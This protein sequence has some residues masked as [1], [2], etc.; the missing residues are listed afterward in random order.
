MAEDLY[1]L[2]SVHHLFYKALGLAERD[3]LLQEEFARF[4]AD[5][6][7]DEEHDEHAEEH[8]ERQPDAVIEHDAEQEYQHGD[9]EKEVRYALRN[10][11]ADG[12]H[13]V[14]VMAH[15]VAV[16]VRIEIL[17]GQAL[18][19]VEQIRSQPMQKALRYDGHQLRVQRVRADAQHVDAD[20]RADYLYKV[21]PG[22]FPA[23]GRA[24]GVAVF[25]A[26]ADDL[27]H[28]VEKDRGGGVGDRREDQAEEHRDHGG[29]MVFEEIFHQSSES[30]F[31]RSAVRN[32]FHFSFR[33]LHR[34]L[35]SANNKGRGTFRCSL[36]GLRDGRR[37]LFLRCS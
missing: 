21:G 15:D 37:P 6:L 3:L 23:C 28:I 26:P 9:R 1:D 13:V 5:V 12:V 34:L 33:H 29:F 7:R 11:L 16:G 18:H 20:H 17:D 19:A 2:L 35:F 32:A 8:D 24:V 30:T 4:T 14:G 36:K 27:Y 22:V 25:Y 31:A 10:E